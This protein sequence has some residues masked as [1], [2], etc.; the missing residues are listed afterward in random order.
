MKYLK[1]ESITIILISIILSFN[2]NSQ[3]E[4]N[5]I[6]VTIENQNDVP[7]EINGEFFS[8][9]AGIQQLINDYNI[10]NVELAVPVPS[11]TTSEAPS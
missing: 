8:T 6:W 10:I 7:T 2:T 1:V 4:I 3:T 9:N 11:Y 5:K